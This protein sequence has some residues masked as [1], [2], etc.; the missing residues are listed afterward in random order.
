MPINTL[1]VPD[2]DKVYIGAS[3]DFNGSDESLRNTDSEVID[4]G[5]DGFTIGAW[6]KPTSGSD[7]GTLWDFRRTGDDSARLRC[8]VD[9]AADE[10]RVRMWTQGAGTMKD[11]TF[12]T[13]G[14]SNG[15][16][17]NLMV[18]WDG[19]GGS[20]SPSR[21]AETIELWHQGSE[22]TTVTKDVDDSITPTNLSRQC[23]WMVNHEQDDYLAGRLWRGGIWN[24]ALTQAAFP[25]L[26]NSGDGTTPNGTGIWRPRQS[27]HSAYTSSD[28][29]GLRHQWKPGED[30]NPGEIDSGSFGDVS[31]G[32]S[33]ANPRDINQDAQN[34]SA[35][36]VVQDSPN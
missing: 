26:Y 23:L 27:G 14:L 31:A 11:W 22:I 3:I 19:P 9:V 35:A 15:V 10:V 6:W 20:G 33:G 25:E 28:A 24:R 13:V 5:D 30:A 21:A 32:G 12:D 17:S 29:A 1:Y 34:I 4:V 36:D 7:A 18:I 2:A 16:W 8:T